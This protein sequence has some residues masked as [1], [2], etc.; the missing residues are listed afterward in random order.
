MLGSLAFFGNQDAGSSLVPSGADI[1]IVKERETLLLEAISVPL[2]VVD[3]LLR[4]EN[5]ACFGEG[6]DARSDDNDVGNI[7]VLR[8][9]QSGIEFPEPAVRAYSDLQV[10]SGGQELGAKAARRAQEP[11]AA[12]IRQDQMV[13]SGCIRVVQIARELT[14]Q[15]APIFVEGLRFS[16]DLDD[17]FL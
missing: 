7:R 6:F 4:E 17:V 3:E 15:I 14:E 10:L 9:L 13:A 11:T 12:S 1:L 5:V 8:A 16:R 2:R